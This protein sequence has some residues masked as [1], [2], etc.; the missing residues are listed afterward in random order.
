MKCRVCP[1]LLVFLVLA[2]QHLFA[3]NHVMKI[4]DVYEFELTAGRNYANPYVEGYPDN[5]P[6]LL[7]V[8]FTA[9]NGPM[10]GRE[11]MVTGFWDGGDT[12][13]VRFAPPSAGT[14][15]Y[16]SVSEDA[17][18][19]GHTGAITVQDVSENEKL[20][21]PP[22][23]GLVAVKKQ[24][25]RAG[26]YFEYADG[27]PFL[28]I[29]DTWWNWAKEGIDFSSIRRLVDD[30]ADKG[31]T[32]GQLFL[33]GRG[34]EYAGSRETTSFLDSSCIRLEV[35]RLGATDEMIRYA[36][37]RGITVWLCG[38]WSGDNIIGIEKEH[39]I[40][41]WKYIVARYAAYN[42]IWVISGEYNMQNYGGKVLSFWN[43]LGRMV[44]AWDPYERLTSVHPTPPG[45]SGG[46][47]APQWSTGDVLHS[48][49]WLD[50][51]Q[52]QIGHDRWRSENTPYSVARDYARHPI[53]PTVV[54]EPWY[55]FVEESTP[56]P[57]SE[58][59]PPTKEI[60]FG[61]WSSLLSGAAGHSYGAGGIWEAHL[62][63]APTPENSWPNEFASDA[64]RYRGGR[65]IGYVGRFFRNCAWWHLE[66]H[67]EIVTGAADLYCAA[68]I[69]KE[70]VVYARWGGPVQLLL[71]GSGEYTFRW[72]DP[73][74]GEF[75]DA[76]QAN[77]GAVL[78]LRTPDNNDWVLHVKKK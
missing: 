44:K 67:P 63:E 77:G 6:A 17:G 29:G 34:F 72:Y 5:A 30:R 59:V 47:E 12:W 56:A 52:I 31:F 55:E 27:T 24:G 38:W 1:G 43:E 16:R 51:N 2:C 33:A 54:T 75:G 50:Y 10:T 69:G 45:W 19:H 66:P 62:P 64:L 65:Q 49:E 71:H 25:E 73:R 8:T 15:I 70:Y 48:E 28:W 22:Y 23:R 42:T 60:R 76:G 40:R 36:N 41:W 18:L 11:I 3:Q 13:K 21:H 14:W 4:W 26:R 74:T 57:R 9:M 61:A 68:D 32:V 37:N 20:D 7:R 53:K 35:G 46:N 78:S 58:N 39:I